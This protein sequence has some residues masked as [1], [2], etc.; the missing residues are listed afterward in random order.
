[1]NTNR[2]DS[3][4]AIINKLNVFVFSRDFPDTS[5]L[6]LNERLL[7]ARQAFER[8][9]EEHLKIVELVPKTQLQIQVEYFDETNDIYHYV[10]VEINRLIQKIQEREREQKQIHSNKQCDVQMEIVQNVQ[11]EKVQNVQEKDERNNVQSAIRA[12][13]ALRQHNHDLRN[14]IQRH[15]RQM[16]RAMPRNVNCHNCNGNHQM[17]R[18][19]DFIDMSVRERLVRVQRLRLCENCFMPNNGPMKH[20]CRFGACRRCRRPHNSLLCLI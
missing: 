2:R 11:V 6:E 14:R 8:F 12:N 18:C 3:Q 4:R 10:V 7:S 17:H 20:R 9:T 19:P 15:H 5:E 1:M 13:N 16:A